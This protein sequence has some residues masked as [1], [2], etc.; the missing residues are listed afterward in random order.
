MPL[1][2]RAHVARG[3]FM[4]DLE[5][6]NL[7]VRYLVG[8][9]AGFSP[10][11]HSSRLLGQNTYIHLGKGEKV[12]ERTNMVDLQHMENRLGSLT[13]LLWI[14]AS[15]PNSLSDAILSQSGLSA[16][17]SIFLKWESDLV[18]FLFKIINSSP[19][20]SKINSTIFSTVSKA[21]SNLTSACWAP[22][23]PWK[24]LL[25]VSHTAHWDPLALPPPPHLTN[26]S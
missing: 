7:K 18:P 3:P 9:W 13:P 5:A 24:P 21:P 14:I 1:T 15:L 16:T 20:A 25:M 17:W 4:G 10:G 26:L 23:S 19:L 12:E 6:E 11:L 2:A 22:P 8:R